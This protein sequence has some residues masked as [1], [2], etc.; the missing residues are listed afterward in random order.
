MSALLWR[1]FFED[2]RDGF[3]QTLANATYVGTHTKAAPGSAASS[4][5]LSG[6]PSR[7]LATSP[8]L[9]SKGKSRKG[10]PSIVFTRADVNF[11][12]GNGTTLLHYL[13]S[14]TGPNAFDFAIALLQVPFL[15]LY[16]QDL[17][18]G[19]TALHRALYHGNV[20]LAQ[21]LMEH[22]IQA[23]GSLASSR[24]GGLIKI[25][26]REGNSPF[27]LYATTIAARDITQW[28]NQATLP[29]PDELETNE[30]SSDDSR[31]ETT[32]GLAGR[33]DGDE[34]FAF[35]SN[36]NLSLGVGNEDDR[37]FP[38]KISLRRP[39]CLAHRLNARNVLDPSKRSKRLEQGGSEADDLDEVPAVIKFKPV[40][41]LD[42]QMAKYHTALMTSD[43]EANLQICGFGP[44]GR[45]G[46]G[47]T[48]TRFRFTSILG[49]GL[50]RKKIVAIAL[51][52]DHT[53][54]V[55]DRGEVFT[56]GSNRFG[57]LGSA[58][59]MPSSSDEEPIQPLP[60]QLF[61][62]LKR[63]MIVGCAA[64][65]LH[66]VVFSSGSL[67]TF[68][69]NEGQLGL[70]ESNAA[71]LQVQSS[72]RKVAASLF[73]SPI[74]MVSATDRATVC[75]LDNHEVYCLANYG[76]SKV[77]FPAEAPANNPAPGHRCMYLSQSQ[78][79]KVCSAGDTVCALNSQGEVYTA[80]VK[81][82]P[83]ARKT[84]TTNPNKIRGLLS[85]AQKVW[86]LR[87]SHMAVHD[88]D[89][90]QDGSIIVCTKAGSV[91]RRVKR[92]KIQ[93]SDSKDMRSKDYK[94]SR[95][96]SLTKICT[97]RSNSFGA[98]AAVRVD[99]YL[100]KANIQVSPN[101]LWRD[102]AP[103]CPL[104]GFQNSQPKRSSF[105]A[106]T[107]K[108]ERE[109]IDVAGIRHALANA[110]DLESEV[111]RVLDR[112]A[113]AEQLAYD[114]RVGTTCSDLRVPCHE[115]ILAAR[116]PL[117]RRG[118]GEFRQNYF[119]SR[120]DI[121]SI[122]Y[123]STGQ[124]LL[125]FQ[126]I[127]VL[128]LLNVIL[129]AYTDGIL[130][131]WNLAKAPADIV[132]RYRQV[133]AELIKLA[134]GIETKGLEQAA[135]LM[136][137]PAKLAHLDFG[138]AIEEPAFFDT[139]DLEIE[140]D[141]TSVKVH[142][143]IMCQRCPFF[144]GMFHGQAAGGWVRA[145]RESLQEPFEPIKVDLKH[146]DP[147][148]FSY[149]LRH[150][151]VGA[152]ESLFDDAR[153]ADL[154]AFLDLVMDVLSAANELML[155]Q[156]SDVCQKC[157]ANYTTARNVCQLA[158]AIAPC[159][160]TQ[161]K[162]AALEYICLNLEGMLENRLLSELDDDLLADLDNVVQA[163]QRAAMPTAR[164]RMLEDELHERYPELGEA[165]KKSQQA[166][167]S[168]MIEQSRLREDAL[169][170]ANMRRGSEFET[171]CPKPFQRTASAEMVFEMDDIES[172]AD[173]ELSRGRNHSEAFER[174]QEPEEASITTSLRPCG[175]PS[176][177]GSLPSQS[178]PS[179]ARSSAFQLASVETGSAVSV[180]NA[181]AKAGQRRASG[182]SSSPW[183][184][185]PLETPK[186]DM[187]QIIAQ[188]S[189]HQTS[190]ISAAISKGSLP[191]TSGSRPSQ[192]E[193]KRQFQEQQQQQQQQIPPATPLSD[194][195]SGQTPPPSAK[196]APWQTV[197]R[198]SR[199]SLK[200]ILDAPE[201]APKSP[202]PK[203]RVASA[204]ALTLRQTI[205]GNVASTRK[206]SA[207]ITPNSKPSDEIR[208]ASPQTRPSA[209]P[210]SSA[211]PSD[212]PNTTRPSRSV[213]YAPPTAEPSLQLSMADI[214]AQQQTEKD[215]L[216]E[217]TTARRSLR[218]IQEEQVFQEW[219]EQEEAA[220]KAR[221]EAEEDDPPMKESEAGRSG[222]GGRKGRGGGRG[223]GRG[224]SRGRSRGRA[225]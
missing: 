95:I 7:A 99:G 83:P 79:V 119:F 53:V 204:P 181:R 147:T 132:T 6:S 8:A 78:I 10:V 143:A 176:I 107:S 183:T 16:M 163:N 102:L 106:A 12:D 125:L 220:T 196:P 76:Y 51:G 66:S 48:A 3:R 214:L 136:A 105:S 77:A 49:G 126:S 129:F 118:L 4:I 116:I 169:K 142:S 23:F 57:Q 130:D 55:S 168:E 114:V 110:T 44:G 182:P 38:E 151:Y 207:D 209:E 64:S 155:D 25:K 59:Q 200:D 223:R 90:S 191:K 172:K 46:T 41:I 62:S 173:Q 192:K 150:I 47:D 73:S 161:F 21:A 217:L 13:A 86:S 56:W 164:G 15:D 42:V 111:S 11:K 93:D 27:D 137:E 180:A 29:P 123:D 108:L 120:P 37:Q 17:E 117:L 96:P 165:I 19:W 92:A 122:E 113:S 140:L 65:A 159:S 98:F 205:P 68:G 216:R 197:T 195:T 128:T 190:N 166:R 34:L 222:R 88:V 193:R 194:T 138:Q 199:V 85:P 109:A 174:L 18:S 80:S 35:G 5:T 224:S 215:V 131:V 178:S 189:A 218:E 208:L 145:R 198:A 28:P 101:S 127:D 187:K 75:L 60:R 210:S 148:V 171:K 30:T 58:P 20:R 39:S 9:K 184:S 100:V 84:S 52:Q 188:A 177:E 154:D 33:K 139:A 144:E 36:K 87:R 89:V 202:P 185:Q 26:D 43:A 146:V 179:L 115:F 14:S 213:R 203:A 71:S 167:I 206:A 61:G 97:V 22:D 70:V 74:N 1:H 170:T 72:P 152:D 121:V 24:A 63:E 45:L 201:D 175:S 40:K 54:A 94:F 2:D 149:V 219:W 32:E 186:L 157:L 158:N 112:L 141:G 160:V 50:A 67:F 69:K 134:S 162:N 212:P 104:G 82:E 103:L 31:P 91:W 124:P 156:L 153:A 211:N 135:R 221:M 133:R 225:S 81:I